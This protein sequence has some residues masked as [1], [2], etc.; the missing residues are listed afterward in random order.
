MTHIENSILDRQRRLEEESVALGVQRYHK[1]RAMPWREGEFQPPERDEAT[2]PPGAALIRRVIGEYSVLIEERINKV[3]SG[4]AGRY[5]RVL[6]SKLQGVNP[7]AI[8]LI[9][10]RRTLAGASTDEA[11]TSLFRAVGSMVEEHMALDSLR[12]DEKNLLEWWAKKAKKTRHEGHSRKIMRQ[13]ARQYLNASAWTQ[14]DQVQIGAFLVELLEEP[15][16]LVRRHTLKKRKR[17]VDVMR[18]TEALKAWL[19]DMHAQCALLQPVRLPM[20]CPPTN[21]TTPWD[22]GYLTIDCR[23]MKNAPR[24]QIDDLAT[25]EMPTVYAAVNSLQQVP[26]RINQRVANVLLALRDA[27]AGAPC[28]PPSEELPIPERPSDIPRDCPISDLSEEHQERLR[29]WKRRATAAYD[30]NASRQS[31][32]IAFAQKVWVAEKFLGE[33]EI[34]F[35]YQID[36][37][38]RVYTIPTEVSPQ[39]DDLG[40]GLLEFADSKPLGEDGAYWLAVHLANCAGVDK[41]TFEERVQW[42][43]DNEAMILRVGVTP[44]D[45]VDE[46]AAADSPWQFLAACVEWAAYVLSGRSD[47]YE[48]ALPVGMDGSC[49]GLQHFSAALRD[50]V[51]ARAVNL[52]DTGKVED[53]YAEVARRVEERI[54]DSEDP[55]FIPWKGRVSRKVVKQPCMTYAYS[56]TVAGMRTQIANALEKMPPEDRPTDDTFGS[57]TALAP[58][59][60][61]C[62]EEV[63]VAAAGAMKWMQ[64]AAGIMTQH[65]RDLRWVAPNG[66]PV[67]QA[68]YKQNS[69]LVA[70]WYCG[71]RY[72]PRLQVETTDLDVR[73]QKAAISPNWVHSL[74]AAHLMDAVLLGKENGLDYWA[75]VHDSFGVH[76]CDVSLLHEVIRHSFVELYQTNWLGELKAD[77]E[78]MMPEGEKLP[79]LPPTG[80]FDLEAVRSASYF[81]A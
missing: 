29:H 37:R 52:I 58:V 81:F 78:M 64:D 62:I 34:Y 21:W 43:A 39:G 38:G 71:K 77:L 4:R 46:W 53:I 25:M 61:K 20:V 19:E 6:Q 66:L 2:L 80:T 57:A 31:K 32:R 9:A 73:R 70:A 47:E 74:D 76:P 11:A 65:G 33:E 16:G 75:M 8:G 1:T 51:G 45:A 41:V 60:R 17:Q 22:G 69:R 40:K 44:E 55:R 26:W 36:T 10:L 3:H 12:N 14:A 42:V 5:A 49:S 67:R 48:C 68:E 30:E 27:P 79:G 63:V 7:Q 13:A 35:P 18:C 72:Q 15:L 23:L 56:A 59:V 24:E 54:A 50:P 28:I